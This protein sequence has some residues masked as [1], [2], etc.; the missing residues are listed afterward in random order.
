MDRNFGQWYLLADANTDHMR[1]ESR[2]RGVETFCKSASI[3]DIIELSR[4]FYNYPN[5]KSEFVDTFQATFQKIDSTFPIEDNN[6]ILSVLAGASLA[7]FLKGGNQSLSLKAAYAITCPSFQNLRSNIIIP[8]IV[9][10]SNEYLIKKS[11]SLRTAQNI[12][13]IQSPKGVLN[14]LSTKIINNMNESSLPEAAQ[15]MSEYLN[16]LS[17]T[18]DR[19][20]GNTNS[21]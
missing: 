16:K 18:L 12:K 5:L 19:V 15:E 1:N 13:S 10:R 6:F 8:E 21:I 9:N 14:E 3:E 2:W 4:L 17:S 7:F 11:S 20:V